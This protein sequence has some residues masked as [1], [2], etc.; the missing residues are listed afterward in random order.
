MEPIG[1]A[2]AVFVAA[3]VVASGWWLWTESLRL[4]A[5]RKADNSRW[6]CPY[7]WFWL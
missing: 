6:V 5:K 4:A 7:S 3:A 2:V 1:L